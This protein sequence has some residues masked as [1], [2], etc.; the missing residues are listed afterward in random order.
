L[1]PPM[2]LSVIADHDMP[3]LNVPTQFPNASLKSPPAE[4]RR[5][6][7]SLRMVQNA[8]NAQQFG[9]VNSLLRN[10][11]RVQVLVTAAFVF[12][13]R[14]FVSG[15]SYVRQCQFDLVIS[16]PARLRLCTSLCTT[17]VPVVQ[18]IFWSFPVLCWWPLIAFSTT[19]TP[20]VCCTAAFTSVSKDLA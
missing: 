2:M 12:L 19:G 18:G 14:F 20:R 6:S 1:G 13:S 7:E 17:T 15:D 3:S 11:V 16:L 8:V 9:V 5:T 10:K 4:F